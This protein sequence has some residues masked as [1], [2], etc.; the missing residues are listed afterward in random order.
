MA[1]SWLAC[2][3]SICRR[4]FLESV[5][6]FFGEA[7]MPPPLPGSVPALARVRWRS[8]ETRNL[9]STDL[10]L[11]RRDCPD[12]AIEGR[13]MQVKSPEQQ[14][15]VEATLVAETE[16]ARGLYSLRYR[17]FR[18]LWLTSLLS[19]AGRTIQQL[20]LGWL[21]FDLTGSTLLLGTVQFIYLFPSL[22][23]APVIGVFID[24]LDRKRM[25]IASQLALAA[26]AT[27][28]AL[29]IAAGTVRPWHILVFALCSGF[30][31]TIIHV[32]RQALIPRLVPTH[33]LMNAISLHSASFNITRI[34]A[35]FM[36][37][38]LLV[39]LGVTGN[40]LL[41]ALLVIGVAAAAFPMRIPRMDGELAAYGSN[42]PFLRQIASGMRYI[43]RN[44][45]LRALF[46]MQFL[47]M[48]LAMPFSSFLP[49]L[50]EEDLHLRA[51]GLGLLYTATGV[52]AL[53]GT[54]F[55][56]AAGNVRQKGLLALGM[57]ALTGSGMI[58]FGWV[59]W[60]P[61]SLL[62][63]A[64]LGA[65]QMLFSTSNMTLVQSNIP[66]GL[67]GRVMSIYQMAHGSLALGTLIM[68][69]IADIWGVSLATVFMGVT[70]LLLGILGLAAL[71]NVR[72]M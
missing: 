35:P 50:A 33:A 45:A 72:R 41:Q 2:A 20:T 52:G 42:E 11:L 40:F 70:L 16:Q 63:L 30:E 12:A 46:A 34:C 15:Q 26:A 24:R 49:A 9:E 59:S 55:L 67:Q 18:L 62:L 65:A 29:D 43:S 28:L 1:A 23:T 6:A 54:G 53:V 48:L 37:G 3:T 5:A 39:N 56:A 66:D 58:A 4:L 32:V 57:C 44:R 10:L 61:A 64:L 27:L 68:G 71:P 51:D 47:F 21:V 19:S 36:A 38:V 25:L 8:G 22:V 17:D 31:N 69:G 14:I 60:L 7:R 13:E